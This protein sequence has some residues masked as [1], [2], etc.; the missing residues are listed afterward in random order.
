MA[1]KKSLRNFLVVGGLII[2]LLLFVNLVS[3]RRDGFNVYNNSQV[4]ALITKASA[5]STTKKEEA[6]AAAAAA[7]AAAAA[8]TAAAAAALQKKKDI[9]NDGRHICDSSYNITGCINA[10]YK[11]TG[12]RLGDINTECKLAY[13]KQF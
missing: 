10:T 8:A 4:T 6:T 9:C 5:A 2:L 1:S 3:F 13:C 7:T 12:E 11:C